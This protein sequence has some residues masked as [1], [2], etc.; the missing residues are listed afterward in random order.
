M[1]LIDN[2]Q[3]LNIHILYK[4]ITFC[5]HFRAFMHLAEVFHNNTTS[6]NNKI[7]IIF[8]FII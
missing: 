6:N 1:M 2:A 8:K 4:A 7:K 5:D 3:H